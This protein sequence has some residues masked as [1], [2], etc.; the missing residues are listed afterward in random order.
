MFI[1]AAFYHDSY[2][3]TPHGWKISDGLQ[4]DLTRRFR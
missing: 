1:G 3:R 2:R 4:A